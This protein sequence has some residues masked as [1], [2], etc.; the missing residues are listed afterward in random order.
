MVERYE[1]GEINGRGRVREQGREGVRD[2]L[3]RIQTLA[4]VLR[5]ESFESLSDVRGAANG[6][7]AL[8][9]VGLQT[10]VARTRSTERGME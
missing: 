2:L 8:A 6:V 5:S 9:V 10:A 4:I 3:F 7:V 1:G